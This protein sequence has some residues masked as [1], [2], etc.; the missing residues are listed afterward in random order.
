MTARG[1]RVEFTRAADRQFRALPTPI[2]RRIASRINTLTTDPHPRGSVKLE[3]ADSIYRL[4]VGDY[5]VLYDVQG[6]LLLV[7]VVG[8]GHRREMYRRSIEGR[9]SAPSN[10]QTPKGRR[11]PGKK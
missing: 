4:R 11:K 2:Q 10:A 1:Y 7:L 3:G 8:V 6:R 5:R 9:R